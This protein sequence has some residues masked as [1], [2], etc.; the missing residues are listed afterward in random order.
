MHQNQMLCLL[1]RLKG[2]NRATVVDG[3]RRADAGIMWK[4]GNGAAKLEE[5]RGMLVLL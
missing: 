4:T 5:N 3:M 2:Q 1:R